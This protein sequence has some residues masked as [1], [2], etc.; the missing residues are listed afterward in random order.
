MS[1]KTLAVG[2]VSIFD[3]EHVF[4]LLGRI[5]DFIPELSLYMTM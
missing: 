1:L 3:F 2:S 4:V 5:Q